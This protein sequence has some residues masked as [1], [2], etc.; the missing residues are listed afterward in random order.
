MR[1][2]VLGNLLVILLLGCGLP[3]RGT[4]YTDSALFTLYEPL[5]ENGKTTEQEIRTWFGDPWAISRDLQ[6]NSQFIYLF[7]HGETRLDIW[8]NKEGIVYDHDFLHQ[9]GERVKDT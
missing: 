4:T 8:L 5:I 2:I 6:G 1:N 7:R 9:G 3:Y